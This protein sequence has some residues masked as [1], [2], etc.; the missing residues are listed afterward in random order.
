MAERQ[1]F[2]NRVT[3]R[4]KRRV[5]YNSIDV[6][7]MKAAHT[8]RTITEENRDL[9]KDYGIILRTAQTYLDR[10]PTGNIEEIL[11]QANDAEVA[12]FKA[13]EALNCEAVTAILKMR[14]LITAI[15]VKAGR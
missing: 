10:I 8:L 2:M 4:N 15:L 5:N 11:G 6:P 9:L 14:R 12:E 1:D 13:I 7:E 3:E